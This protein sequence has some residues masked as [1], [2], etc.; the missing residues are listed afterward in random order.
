[1]A[2]LA[3]RIE[4][5][6]VQFA[7]DPPTAPASLAP[8]VNGGIPGGED[9]PSA[10]AET[11]PAAVRATPPSELEPVQPFPGVAEAVPPLADAFGTA[12]RLAADA[13]AAAVALENLKRL[14]EERRLAPSRPHAAR[15]PDHVEIRA[16]R[17]DSPVRAHARALQR[18]VPLARS[19]ALPTLARLPAPPEAAA[20]DWRGFFAGVAIAAA[21]GLVL[22]IYL[23]AG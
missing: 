2:G 21:F 10:R 18:A 20:L 17:A 14:L 6:G 3:Q 22:Y 8:E 16:P 13:N 1:L 9:Q 5:V 15:E 19:V 12:A 4:A 11:A 23:I 7:A